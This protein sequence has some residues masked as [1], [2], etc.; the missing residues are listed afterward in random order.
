MKKKKVAVKNIICFAAIFYLLFQDKILL[1]K[2]YQKCGSAK[3]GKY[4]DGILE[5]I[6][7]LLILESIRKD[8]RRYYA[9]NLC[10]RPFWGKS[11]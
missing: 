8:R 10:T 3:R 7:H 11:L 6:W 5:S 9:G 4:A 1:Y 2:G